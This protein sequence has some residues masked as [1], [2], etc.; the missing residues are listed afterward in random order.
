[1]HQA[2]G[3]ARALDRSTQLILNLTTRPLLSQH[4]SAALIPAND[5][6]RVLADIDTDHGDFT[7]ELL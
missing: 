4:D 7:I 6:E 5:V 1:M 3:I 2:L